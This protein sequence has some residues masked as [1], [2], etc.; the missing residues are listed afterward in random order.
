MGPFSRAVL[1]SVLVLSA[2]CGASGDSPRLDAGAGSAGTGGG[3]GTSGQAGVN[4]GAGSGQAG[5]GSSD[6][7]VADVG[8]AE[9]GRT[10]AA[11]DAREAGMDTAGSDA[12]PVPGNGS[13][14]DDNVKHLGRW[15]VSTPSQ[16][17]SYW[18]GAYLKVA[19]TGTTLKMKVGA[20]NNYYVVLDDRAP[21]KIANA[22]GEVNLTPTPLPAGNHLA[23]ISAGK[24]Y[25]YEFRFQGLVL[26]AG[27]VTMPPRVQPR[28]VEFIGDS[29]T[30]GYTDT[31]AD[32]SDYAWIVAEK[33]KLEHAQIAYPGIALVDTFGLNTDK[34]GMERQYFKLKPLGYS[35]NADW[36]ASAYTPELIVINLGT[37]DRS[38]SVPTAKFQTSY[39][40]FLSAL[41]A[42]YPAAEIFAMRCLNG[43][44]AAQTQAAV[45]AR[46]TAGDAKVHFVDTTGWLTAADY[47]DGTHP[48]DAG[49]AK[50]AA[51]LEPI[52]TPY[53]TP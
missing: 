22:N 10:D 24:D 37:N 50:I 47:T 19:F 31:L 11:G 3:A 26:D 2:A 40:G 1:L 43:S 39:T 30:A 25:G 12:K 15:D 48:S 45:T 14:S 42:R 8:A 36:P 4:G 6:A 27:A 7:S 41:R 34:S 29:I 20:A 13:L 16:H 21:L 18:G 5:I 52:L 9:V 35:T 28:F 46:T 33:L 49:Q 23:I 44:M 53:L 32:V 38:T 17:V 51:R